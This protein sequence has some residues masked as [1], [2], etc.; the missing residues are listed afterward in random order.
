[1]KIEPRDL[2]IGNFVTDSE[3]RLCRIENIDSE[4]FSEWNGSDE[5]QLTFITQDG[6]RSGDV[7]GIPLTPDTL[8]ILGAYHTVEGSQ[9]QYKLP[10]SACSLFFRFN[11]VDCYSELDGIY[12]GGQLKFVHQV[13]N[14]FRS[15]TGKELVTDYLDFKY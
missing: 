4:R 1:M 2:M 7:F 13:Q 14:L 15:L 6:V 10:I 8:K 12:L 9:F 5:Y 11:G 3:Q